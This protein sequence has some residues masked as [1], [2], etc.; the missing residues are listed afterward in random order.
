[1]ILTDEGIRKVSV[2]WAVFY[3]IIFPYYF[4][5]YVSNIF[6]RT[7]QAFLSHPSSVRWAVFYYIIFPYYFMYYVYSRKDNNLENF[8]QK[9]HMHLYLK[10]PTHPPYI[11]FI[12]IY[13]IYSVASENAVLV[14]I[15]IRKACARVLTYTSQVCTEN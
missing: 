1:M 6:L 13:S 3:Y 10:K 9:L 14:F 4:M 15:G 2:R 7:G 11:Y 8:I 12:Y 5:Y